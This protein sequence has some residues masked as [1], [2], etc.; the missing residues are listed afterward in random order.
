MSGFDE[1]SQSF[2]YWDTVGGWCNGY[3]DFDKT[4]CIYTDTAGKKHV[5]VQFS[6]YQKLRLGW[7]SDQ[8]TNTHVF[9]GGNI[10][11]PLQA[12]GSHGYIEKQV[13]AVPL[14]DLGFYAV[15]YRKR[16]VDYY[17]GG[18]PEDGVLVYY[19]DTS[20]KPTDPATAGSCGCCT[21][22]N[23]ST[24]ATPS[25]SPTIEPRGP[26]K[27]IVLV[28]GPA[29][30]PKLTSITP[31]YGSSARRS[32]N[33]FLPVTLTGTEFVPLS[34]GHW[35]AQLL[36]G[37]GVT[38]GGYNGPTTLKV[39]VEDNLLNAGRSGFVSVVN[40]AANMADSDA[41]RSNLLPFFVSPS[42]AATVDS[43]STT[44]TTGATTSVVAGSSPSPA[45]AQAAWPRPHSRPI[46][47]PTPTTRPPIAGMRRSSTSITRSRRSR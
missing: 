11:Y 40:W 32:P 43:A 1:T 22:V 16:D 38:G 41:T 29:P 8:P 13:L 30:T 26:K 7:L 33:G 20:S 15:E 37:Q 19:V 34:R 18:L 23:P 45:R 17:E 14:E 31:N 27:A 35:N 2:F 39:R 3:Y 36:D 4:R 28:K 5:A 24:K 46:P 25:P 21:R 9:R 42:G 12:V 10:S 44:A 6:A 47:A